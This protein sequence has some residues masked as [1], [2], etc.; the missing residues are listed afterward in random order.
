VNFLFAIKLSQEFLQVSNIKNFFFNSNSF[1]FF[2]QIRCPSPCSCYIGYNFACQRINLES[3]RKCANHLLVCWSPYKQNKMD[4]VS[5]IRLKNGKKP[6][7]NILVISTV[8]FFS[9]Y[10]KTFKIFTVCS[11]KDI[12]KFYLS[13][14]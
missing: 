4:C 3:N 11:L 5:I 6:N 9:F 14:N 12:P 8:I 13:S 7:G 2:T 10:S 1:F